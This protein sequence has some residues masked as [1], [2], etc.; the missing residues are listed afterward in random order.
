MPNL[1]YSQNLISANYLYFE[2]TT[3][4]NSFESASSTYT[5]LETKRSSFFQKKYFSLV[6]LQFCW[7]QNKTL[8]CRRHRDNV[9]VVVCFYIIFYINFALNTSQVRL[10][11]HNLCYRRS[12]FVGFCIYSCIKYC[13]FATNISTET[14]VVWM[15]T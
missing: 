13:I 8:C 5:L 10:S 2:I 6:L 7:K 12:R 15:L 1:Y 14:G 3:S 11:E 4:H 9:I